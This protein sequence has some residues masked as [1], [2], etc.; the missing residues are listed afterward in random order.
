MSHLIPEKNYMRMETVQLLIFIN[1]STD[2]HHPLSTQK[3]QRLNEDP[4]YM[5]L[6]HQCSLL[7]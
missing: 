6:E 1:S 7:H 5:A 2:L 4:S 3:Y